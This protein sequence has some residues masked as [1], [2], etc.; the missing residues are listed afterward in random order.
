MV[1]LS[2]MKSQIKHTNSLFPSFA[3]RLIID[4]YP[5]ASFMK[6]LLAWGSS[7]GGGA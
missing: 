6:V 1:K 7:L 3:T 5:A 4:Y 2:E